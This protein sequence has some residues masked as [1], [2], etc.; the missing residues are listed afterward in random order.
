MRNQSQNQINKMIPKSKKEQFHLLLK[1]RKEMLILQKTLVKQDPHHLITLEQV[2][3][4]VKKKE[5]RNKRKNGLQMLLRMITS[6]R[7]KCSHQKTQKAKILS[8]QT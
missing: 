6:K 7:L 3:V 4:K 1:S 8:I 2:Q 5:R